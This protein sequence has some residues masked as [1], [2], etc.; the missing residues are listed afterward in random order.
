MKWDG[1]DWTFLGTDPASLADKFRDAVVNSITKSKDGRL[2]ASGTFKNK[3]TKLEYFARY[4]TSITLSAKELKTIGSSIAIY[5]NPSG[6]AVQL[7][8]LTEGSKT[9][10]LTLQSLTGQILDKK[11]P[12]SREGKLNTSFS[13]EHLP[14]GT[15]IIVLQDG[16]SST[17]ARLEVIH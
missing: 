2:H 15:Y 9:L 1:T 11:L 13:V 17:S 7:S 14:S 3:V 12:D 6:S 5:P 8:L 10:Q 4:N 16:E